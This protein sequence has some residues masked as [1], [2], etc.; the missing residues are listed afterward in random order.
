MG[1]PSQ[2]CFQRFGRTAGM[3][4]A[5]AATRRAMGVMGNGIRCRTS[6]AATRRNIGMLRKLGARESN[7]LRMAVYISSFGGPE[8]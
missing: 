4:A 6:I 3:L 2:N 7:A 1:L 5:K 8:R